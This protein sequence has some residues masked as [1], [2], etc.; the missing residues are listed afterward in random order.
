M[1]GGYA[2]LQLAQAPV[3]PAWVPLALAMLTSAASAWLC[4]RAFIAFV[5]RVG[6]LPFVVYR[7]LLG[8]ALLVLY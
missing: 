6:M 8:A 3:E 1:A 4:I 7:V 2:A 5:E